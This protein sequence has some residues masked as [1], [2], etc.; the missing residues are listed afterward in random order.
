[1]FRHRSNRRRDEDMWRRFA[2]TLYLLAAVAGAAHG[3]AAG[4]AAEQKLRQEIEAVFT[5][6]LDAFNKGD[7]R[8][9]AVFF[10]PGAPAINPAGEVLADT[11]DYVNRVEQQRQ[12]IS[13]TTATIERVQAIGSEAAYAT[14]AYTTTF[15]PANNLSQRQGIWLQVFE[16]RGDA[17]KI[18]ASSF[19]QVGPVKTIGK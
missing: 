17:W 11:Q 6:W 5:G 7:G 18:G 15:G 4:A 12:R 14:G 10:A 2:L 3:Q 9:A 8:A 19:T 1:M 13:K 16:R